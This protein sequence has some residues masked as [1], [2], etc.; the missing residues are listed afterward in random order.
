MFNM[1]SASLNSST[2]FS[3]PPPLSG[4]GIHSNVQRGGANAAN[5]TIMSGIGTLNYS[6][7]SNLS[8]GGLSS[9]PRNNHLLNAPPFRKQR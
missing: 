3:L 9:M 4:A 6:T 5:S 2:G 7:D 8:G 1:N